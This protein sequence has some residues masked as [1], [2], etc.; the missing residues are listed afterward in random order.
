MFSHFFV[1]S[2][3][4]Q[5][6]PRGGVHEVEAALRGPRVVVGRARGVGRQGRVGRHGAVVAEVAI[7]VAGLT[8]GAGQLQVNVKELN[9]NY[10]W[11]GET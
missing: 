11:D 1:P 8:D 9:T 5:A 10:Q 7:V 2:Y 4:V 6:W 3:L